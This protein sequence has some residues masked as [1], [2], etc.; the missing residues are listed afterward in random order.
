MNWRIRNKSD[1]I[2]FLFW[3]TYLDCRLE[4]ESETRV[5]AKKVAIKWVREIPMRG[6]GSRARG[7]G[8]RDGE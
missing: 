1:I 7:D 4:N 8:W 6:N 5:E 3:K 2:R